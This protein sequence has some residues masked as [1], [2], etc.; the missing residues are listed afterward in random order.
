MRGHGG[1]EM[2]LKTIGRIGADLELIGGFSDTAGME[3][4]GFQNHSAAA[5]VDGGK[6]ASHHT[7]EGGRKRN[8]SNATPKW[9]DSSLTRRPDWQK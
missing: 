3:G 8:W 6:S 5:V 7:R 1:T 9:T 2:A 4:R